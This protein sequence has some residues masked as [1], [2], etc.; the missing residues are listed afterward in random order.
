M[1]YSFFTY[2]LCLVA[3][4]LAGVMNSI[5]GGGTVLTF[6]ALL[7][8]MNPILANGTSTFALLPGSLAGAWTFR[9]FLEPVRPILLKLIGPSIL[10]A[11][12]GS[13]LVI[14]YPV[15]FGE[16]YPWLML[17]ATLL[18]LL[19]KPIQ[20]WTGIQHFQAPSSR[21]LSWIIGFQFLISIYGGYFGAGIG[22]LMIS[23]LGYMGFSNIVEINA[24]K[25]VLASIINF[26]TLIIF[27]FKGIIVW[28]M[29]IPMSFTAILGGY[30]GAVIAKKLS[31]EMVR[32]IVIF[33]GSTVTIYLFYKQFFA[34]TSP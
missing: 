7:T 12:I 24:V 6:P 9:G 15:Q 19:Q 29:A 4:L 8:T 16:L 22:I 25:T 1:E 14:L 21:T 5:A 3:A 28:E 26:V 27:L 32:T 2:L 18:F 23:T 13:L 30:L 17:L 10:G 34:P 33:I 20:R 31:K 11:V